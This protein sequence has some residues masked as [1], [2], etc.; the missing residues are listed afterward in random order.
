MRFSPSFLD[1]IRERVPISDVIG[2]RVTWDKRKTQ[3]AKGDYWA[4]C[5]FHG[6]KTPSFHCE[7]QKGRYHCFGCGVSG[8]HFR[9]MVELEGLSFPE[10]VERLADEAGIPMPVADPRMIEKEK[11]KATLFDVMNI[12][13]QYFKDQLQ[14]AGGAKA[15]SYLRDRGLS[16]QVQQTFGLG[17]APNSRNGLKEYLA[18]KD[19]SKEQI[20]ACG[21]VVFG[22][23]IAVSYDRFRGRIMF[24]IEDA[25]GRVIAFGG[26][27]MDPDVPAKYLNSPET[28]LF[29]KGNVLYNLARARKPANDVKSVIVAEGYMDV[30]ALHAAGIENAVAPLGTA[31]TENQLE[32][33]WRMTPEPVLCF[34]GDQAGLRAAYRSVDLALPKLVSGRS[35]RFCLLPD[36]QDPDDVVKEGGKAAFDKLLNEAVPLHEF[37]VS[38]RLSEM[39]IDGPEKKAA[40]EKQIYQDANSIQDEIV[41]KYY[42]SHVRLQ[43]MNL[44]SVNDKPVPTKV[45]AEI[46]RKLDERRIIRTILG[47]LVEFPAL[48]SENIEKIAELEF[49]SE[50]LRLFATDLQ[51]LFVESEDVAVSDV[52]EKLSESFI[53]V[54]NAIH[55]DNKDKQVTNAKG[56]MVSSIHGVD[57]GTRAID[58]GHQ[59]K[60]LFPMVSSQPPL[61]LAQQTL[62]LLF[63]QIEVL[64]VETEAQNITSF[65]SEEE[66]EAFQEMLQEARDRYAEAER[67]LDQSYHHHAGRRWIGEM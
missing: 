31:L 23:D 63:L 13:A 42:R 38:R 56:N 19:V 44:F 53:F 15:R 64:N 59:L 10:S 14:A 41:R 55:G 4:C 61:E 8:D 3:A 21:M 12:A 67:E 57:G 9:F 16:Q 28:E 37:F 34:D 40:F 51:L 66:F 60:V 29:S 50:P 1:Q 62:N 2:R 33:L 25:R 39:S 24:P 46:S 20:E 58:R 6:E 5:P 11:A 7:N 43:L 27:A 30:I 54:L 65:E 49:Y 52:Y 17:F 32:L 18:S 35:L 48:I 22:P 26:R 45:A 47:F 36:G